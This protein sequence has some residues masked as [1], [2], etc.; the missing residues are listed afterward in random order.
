MRKS[1]GPDLL[2]NIV[3]LGPC[4]Q[5]RLSVG[6]ADEGAYTGSF[7]SGC[8]VAEGLLA[9]IGGIY[10]YYKQG[11]IIY[12][13]VHRISDSHRGSTRPRRDR[14]DLEPWPEPGGRPRG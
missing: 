9:D 6:L 5:E 1:T 14:M 11:V 4:S 8:C 12:E 13:I 7:V 2:L 3:L 10:R